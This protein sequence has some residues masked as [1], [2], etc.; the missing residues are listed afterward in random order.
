LIQLLGIPG[1]VV[2]TNCT[3]PSERIKKLVI[4]ED[5]GPFTVFLLKPAADA[6]K[7]VMD[8]VR[9]QN[10]DLYASLATAGGLCVRY[11]RPVAGTASNRFSMHSWGTA[12]DIGINGV[13]HNEKDKVMYGLL[14]LVPFF[15]KH[16]FIWDS[17]DGIHFEASEQTLQQWSKDGLLDQR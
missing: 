7:L 6:V 8:D 9:N 10:P 15:E 16:G 4:Q 11:L 2:S 13:F 5:V 17:E 12:I 14:S 1:D 3:T